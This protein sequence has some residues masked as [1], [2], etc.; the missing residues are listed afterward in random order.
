MSTMYD[1]LSAGKSAFMYLLCGLQHAMWKTVNSAPAIPTFVPN[2]Q[3]DIISAHQTTATVRYF[4]T[5]LCIVLDI[6]H[7]KHICVNI[8]VAVVVFVCFL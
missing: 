6:M 4:Y 8:N 3:V 5:L 1:F 2:V 7:N